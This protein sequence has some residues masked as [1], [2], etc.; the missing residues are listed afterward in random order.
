[1]SP[2]TPLCMQHRSTTLEQILSYLRRHPE[3]TTTVETARGLKTPV[4][5]VRDAIMQLAQAGAVELRGDRRWYAR[6]VQP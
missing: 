3:G 6:E 2:L 5:E 1:M 4:L